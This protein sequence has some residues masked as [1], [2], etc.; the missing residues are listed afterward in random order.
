MPP[1]NYVR[2]SESLT[3]TKRR[4][5]AAAIRDEQTEEI[6]TQI[7]R[8][9]ASLLFVSR[10]CFPFL[11]SGVRANDEF[12]PLCSRKINFAAPFQKVR[13]NPNMDEH[14][15]QIER[16]GE[17]AAE[18]QAGQ[19]SS[20]NLSEK[21]KKTLDKFVAA[22]GQLDKPVSLMLELAVKVRKVF[23]AKERGK[24][25]IWNG[26]EFH[27]FDEFVE[28]HFPY[29]G[30]QMRRWL[31]A[32]GLTEKKFAHKSKALVAAPAEPAAIIP[33]VAP[34]EPAA[35]IIPAEKVDIPAAG[36]APALPAEKLEVGDEFQPVFEPDWG[37]GF[38]HRLS[39]ARGDL[40]GIKF[41]MKTESDLNPLY[42]EEQEIIGRIYGEFVDLLAPKGYEIGHGSGGW[43]V[44]KKHEDE[45]EPDP[46]PL[47]EM[48]EKNP[49][50]RKNGM[51]EP[52]WVRF[53]K[54]IDRSKAQTER[55][56]KPVAESEHYQ[57]FS[58]GFGNYIL[59]DRETGYGKKIFCHKDG[60]TRWL[61]CA[62]Q[63]WKQRKAIDRKIAR[64]L[65]EGEQ[66]LQEKEKAANA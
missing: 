33:A 13:I 36:P 53:T 52:C 28:H 37:V 11:Y 60:L 45:P 43:S 12:L 9:A 38:M 18:R 41:A 22:A 17:L 27:R 29:S 26:I 32:E 40:A 15:R 30:R 14:A 19:M 61:K 7:D 49:A 25:I 62:E 4:C 8:R 39:M 2:N 58:K 10:A 56:K 54:S 24:A 23:K 51:C 3:R 31:S 20:S 66:I 50:T 42:E 35:A 63:S 6:E 47:C 5:F 64:E 21:D 55:L 44:G 65:K 57:I 16:L 48:C 1:E 34:A 46:E 59:K